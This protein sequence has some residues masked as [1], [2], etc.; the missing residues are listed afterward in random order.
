MRCHYGCM[1]EQQALGWGTELR[2]RSHVGVGFENLVPFYHKAGM[3]QKC[4]PPHREPP[5]LPRN[6]FRLRD[7]QCDKGTL[8]SRRTTP[9]M[10]VGDGRGPGPGTSPRSTLGGYWLSLKTKRQTWESGGLPLPTPVT[11]GT[12]LGVQASA[13]LHHEGQPG[14][15]EKG[16]WPGRVG[17]AGKAV[18]SPR[19]GTKSIARQRAGLRASGTQ[20]LVRLGFI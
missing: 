10:A 6:L 11:L 1:P 8:H 5:H 15:P 19:V 14:L 20:G 16:L 7:T 18:D 3:A 12:S 2:P 13:P 17:K 4:Q 9:H